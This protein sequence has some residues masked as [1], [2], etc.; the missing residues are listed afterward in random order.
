[1]YISKVSL[2]NFRNFKS[3]VFKFNKG[4]NT[5][6]GENG[7]GKTNLFFALRLLLD[8]SLPNRVANLI[9]SDFNRLLKQWK[10]HWIIIDI[11]FLNLGN[12]EITSMISHRME[13]MDGSKKGN[14]TY[15]FRPKKTI[16]EKLY[17]LSI[18]ED[19]NVD[20]IE[21]FISSLTIDDYEYEYLCRNTINY[22]DEDEY[23]KYVGD[24]E[25]FRFPNPNEDMSDKYGCS[26]RSGNIQKEITCTFIK[27]LRDV[28]TDL[29]NTRYSPLLSLLRTTAEKI[30]TYERRAI[31]ES[32]KNLNEEISG[33]DEIKNISK[34]IRRTLSNAVGYTYA[35]NIDI[36]S[37]LPDDINKL[38]NNLAI[39]VGD[40]KAYKGKL[41][42]LSL[43]GA[44]LIYLS[45]KLY[46]YEQKQALDKVAHFLLIEE[47]E[48]HIHTH[49]QKTLF[50][51]IENDE[52]QI[53]IS[54]HST[55]ISSVSNIRSVNVLSTKSN[56]TD[57]FLP[58]N[59]LDE[60][61]S[62]RIERYLDAVRSTL[63]FAKGV[64]LVEGD[65][66]MIM[67]PAMVKKTFGIGLDE[68]GV[69]LI[70]M[71]SA[72]FQ[73]ICK[74]FHDDRMR[75]K[76]S[77]IT[78]SDKSYIE[79]GDNIEEDNDE[80]KKLRN[81]QKKGIERKRILDD[82]CCNNRWIEPFYAEYTFEV[83]FIKENNSKYIIECLDEIY[84]IQSYK[85][86]SEEKL[87]DS[88]ISIKGREILR[89][90]EKVGKGWFALMVSE[91]LNYKVS[92]P[93][94]ILDAVYF[95]ASGN[96]NV[97][98]FEKMVEYRITQ[99]KDEHEISGEIFN[100]IYKFEGK[101]LTKLKLYT[102][103]NPDDV[104]SILLK[105]HFGDEIC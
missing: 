79:L 63:L 87:K 92:I 99:L 103:K 50:N 27:A 38:M 85:D 61:E 28:I 8:D 18:K 91:R 21:T 58:S 7:S 43:G 52:T 96:L 33:I 66:E 29:K 59:K 55:H 64:I 75:R 48:A 45:L 65:A 13:H 37:E 90:A 86:G 84:E 19:K 73:N 12:G 69:S 95:S 68:I 67:I 4:I 89:L 97:N 78:D 35:P 44:N 34:G 82:L 80:E 23:K 17:D 100:Q 6:I 9:E 42:E 47:P 31:T 74:I 83:D 46:E 54:T 30:S 81:S 101:I 70:N 15:V 72:V 11:E 49:I 16:R 22:A 94:Y 76:C 77:I 51:S 60:N 53:I 26:L 102:E 71:N 93:K 2:R 104:L 10:G 20:E 25:K 5:L 14:L 36:H 39:W 1:M 24:L 98:H 62:K 105:K 41:H 3:C 32:I 40:N 57:V 56:E 88:Q